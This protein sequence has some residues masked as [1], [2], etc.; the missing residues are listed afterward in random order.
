MTIAMN[1]VIGKSYSRFRCR[2]N[3]NTPI[4]Y[5]YQNVMPT[6]IDPNT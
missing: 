6:L 1:L 3:C 4:P 5:D 2:F